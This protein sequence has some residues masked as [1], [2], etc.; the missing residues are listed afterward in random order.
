MEGGGW[1]RWSHETWKPS[2]PWH[3]Q[4]RPEQR[5]VRTGEGVKSRGG[6]QNPFLSESP[7]IYRRYSIRLVKTD[8]MSFSDLVGSQ[9]G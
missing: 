3:C 7:R 8:I 4:G 6:V 9:T 5:G 2:T 1:G